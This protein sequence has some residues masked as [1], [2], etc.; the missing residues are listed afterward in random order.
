MNKH[1]LNIRKKA[2][3]LTSAECCNYYKGTCLMDE[4]ECHVINDRYAT[5]SDGMIDCDWFWKAVLPIQPDLERELLAELYQMGGTV[6]KTCTRCGK[7]YVPLSNRQR[8]CVSCKKAG[9]RANGQ[10]RSQRHRN[11]IKAT[12]SA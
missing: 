9:E 10:E 8:Y 4:T 5:V 2:R 6:I 3:A 12:A 1:D 7:P 11:K